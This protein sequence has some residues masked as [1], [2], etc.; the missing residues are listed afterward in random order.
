MLHFPNPTHTVC[1]LSAR[2]HVV[3]TYITNALFGPITRTSALCP[4]RLRHTRSP[5][6]G[7]WCHSR[8]TL[9]V[10][11]SQ[12]ARLYAT[13]ARCAAFLASFP[14]KDTQ[15]WVGAEA[16]EALERQAVQ[17]KLEVARRMDAGVVTDQDDQAFGNALV[18]I[19]EALTQATAALGQLEDGETN[20]RDE[21]V[22]ERFSGNGTGK[23]S[24]SFSLIT[25][26]SWRATPATPA[27]R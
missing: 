25:Q 15:T 7:T 22:D 5:I 24:S 11:Q 26:M 10:E 27:L 14:R 23:L 9:F 6:H 8:L 3:T 17:I 13:A 1:E 20:P 4:A 18:N 21:N 19:A 2:N 16:L 12:A